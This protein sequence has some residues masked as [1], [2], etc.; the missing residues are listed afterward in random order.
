M[1][2]LCLQCVTELYGTGPSDLA[3]MVTKQ[4]ADEGLVARAQ[5]DECGDIYVDHEGKCQ[6]KCCEKQHG[7]Y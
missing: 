7:D 3:G 1:T 2:T 4:Q 6:C 5:C